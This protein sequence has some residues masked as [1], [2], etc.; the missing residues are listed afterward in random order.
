MSGRTLIWLVGGLLVLAVGLYTASTGRW[1]RGVRRDA[2]APNTP[3]TIRASGIFG[4][5]VGIVVI[6]FVLTGNIK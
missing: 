4:I 5:L 2:F 3:A 6:A 1:P